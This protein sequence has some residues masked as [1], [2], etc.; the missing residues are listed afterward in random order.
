MHVAVLQAAVK[1]IGFVILTVMV[2]KNT[3]FWNITPCSLLKFSQY[4][5]EHTVSICRAE[6]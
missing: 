2:M 1:D 5:E 6:E 3:V 4:L